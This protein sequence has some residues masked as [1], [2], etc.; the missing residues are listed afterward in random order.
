MKV[1]LCTILLYLSFF[2]SL[3]LRVN[4]FDPF[5]GLFTQNLQSAPLP[6]NFPSSKPSH[7]PSVV[8]TDHPTALPSSQPTRKPTTQPSSKPSNN[9]SDV[10]TDHP[11]ALPSSQ[12][13]RNPTTQPSSQPTRQPSGQPLACPS[14]QPS[15]QPSGFPSAQPSSV[16]TSNPTLRPCDFCV[17]GTYYKPEECLNGPSNGCVNCPMGYSCVGGCEVPQPC[18]I[19]SYQPTFGQSACV[20]CPAGTFNLIP[21]QQ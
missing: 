2:L 3:V 8:P 16:P 7:N 20:T 19:G 10:P 5:G 4:S 12:P 15:D 18:G 17:A 13:T 11:T 14:S 6:T 9:P 1:S 21:G